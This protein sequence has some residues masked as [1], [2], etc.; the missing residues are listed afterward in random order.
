[1]KQ[2]EIASEYEMGKGGGRKN[3]QIEWALSDCNRKKN[4]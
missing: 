2:N 3:G 1:M 4:T